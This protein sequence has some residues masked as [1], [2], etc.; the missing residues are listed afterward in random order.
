ML[1]F[2]TDLITIAPEQSLIYMDNCKIH[3]T[4]IEGKELSHKAKQITIDYTSP[5]FFSTPLNIQHT[6]GTCNMRHTSS[7]QIGQN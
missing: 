2:L 4:E 3:H 7:S 6:Q 1:S 5:L